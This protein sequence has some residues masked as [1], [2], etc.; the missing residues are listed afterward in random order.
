[1]KLRSIGLK[2]NKDL[3]AYNSPECQQLLAIYEEYY[4]KNGFEPPWVGYMIMKE[5]QVVGSCSFVT[6]PIDGKV[7]IAYWTF[8][9]FEG[10][11]IASFACKE[12]ITIAKE[13]NPKI[14]IVAK[15]APEKNASTT[16]LKKNGFLY[17][18]VVQDEDIGDAWLW[19]FPQ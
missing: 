7:E 3:E 11:G 5:G 10:Q 17:S 2:E 12:L 1:M 8:K 9:D 18:K 16:I 13:A 14:T 4:L 19:V 6:A 15:T